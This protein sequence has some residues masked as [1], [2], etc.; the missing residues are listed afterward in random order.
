MG[1]SWALEGDFWSFEAHL[2]GETVLD[3]F[4]EPFWRP[5]GKQKRGFR[6]RGDEIL[7]FCS[8]CKLKA[9]LEAML[10]L[11]WGYVGAKLGPKWLQRTSLRHLF[12]MLICMID[13]AGPQQ[14]QKSR[15]AGA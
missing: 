11:C 3:R 7:S 5:L 12:S 14:N 10:G 6:V 2:E 9:I 1:P 8:N 15:R 13:L 4:R